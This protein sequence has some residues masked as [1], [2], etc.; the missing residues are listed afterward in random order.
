MAYEQLDATSL[1]VLASATARLLD[2]EAK[3]NVDG[4]TLALEPLPSDVAIGAWI[5]AGA[6]GTPAWWKDPVDHLVA[7]FDARL[8]DG[9]EFSI[10]PAPRRAV[11][12]D[13]LSLIFGAGDRLLTLQRVW[14]RVHRIGVPRPQSAA[15]VSP[16]ERAV[17]ETEAKL[18]VT[19]EQQVRNNAGQNP[20]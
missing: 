19:L 14:L 16:P 11:G 8:L 10:R 1:L 9:R 15:F 12:P 6:P 4:Y 2:I 20:Q 5:A 3:L 17:G 18:W 13:L 7:G